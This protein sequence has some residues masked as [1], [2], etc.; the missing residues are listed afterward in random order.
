MY[1]IGE[2]CKSFTEYIDKFRNHISD[3]KQ[4]YTHILFNDEIV[5]HVGVA[6]IGL[7][8]MGHGDAETG[9]EKLEETLKELDYTYKLIQALLDGQTINWKLLQLLADGQKDYNSSTP[10]LVSFGS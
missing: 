5:N 10:E 4:F 3:C 6:Y 8:F 1:G 7:S 2:K 9:L